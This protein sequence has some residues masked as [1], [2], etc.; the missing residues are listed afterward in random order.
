LGEALV[1]ADGAIALPF[2]LGRI[3]TFNEG[4]AFFHDQEQKLKLFR[5]SG[6]VQQTDAL[7]QSDSII[8]PSFSEGLAAVGSDN[9]YSGYIDENGEWLIPP[10][11]DWA[12]EFRNGLA[13]VEEKGCAGLIDKAG[14]TVWRFDGLSFPKHPFWPD[15]PHSFIGRDKATDIPCLVYYYRS[16][17]PFPGLSEITNASPCGSLGAHDVKSGGW[18]LFQRDGLPIPGARF[19]RLKSFKNGLAAAQNDNGRWGYIDSVG[20]W[21]IDA[22]FSY[23]S[24]F[25]SGYAIVR[26]GKDLQLLNSLG[27]TILSFQATRAYINQTQSIFGE[28]ESKSF[29]LSF[30]GDVIWSS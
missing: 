2:G 17:S 21:I 12:W 22:Q 20:C 15:H 29:L 5:A 25:V 10:Q 4:L 11:F 18:L 23:A 26:S 9:G 13:L 27:Q 30:T 3:G 14:K 24:D 28:T 6:E 1:A 19:K 16:I 7:P 8:L